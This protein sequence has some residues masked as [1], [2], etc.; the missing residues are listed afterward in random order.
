MFHWWIVLL[1]LTLKVRRTAIEGM[2]PC[3][4]ALDVAPLPGKIIKNRLAMFL[5]EEKICYKMVCY[6]L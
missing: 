6:T 1:T 3:S 5:Q 2:K 4:L